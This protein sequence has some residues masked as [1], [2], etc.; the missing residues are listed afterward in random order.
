ML[1]RSVS[2]HL[3]GRIGGVP[4]AAFDDEIGRRL[5]DIRGSRLVRRTNGR[6]ALTPAGHA[7]AAGMAVLYAALRIDE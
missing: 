7:I 4:N 6:N 5:G 1:I 2:L 3:L